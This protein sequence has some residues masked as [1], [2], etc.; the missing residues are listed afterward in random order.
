[1]I[2]KPNNTQCEQKAYENL[3]KLFWSVLTKRWI[4]LQTMGLFFYEAF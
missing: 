3:Y 1:M 2:T 4:G